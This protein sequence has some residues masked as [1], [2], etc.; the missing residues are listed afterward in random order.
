MFIVLFGAPGVGKG[1]QAEILSAKLNIA[2]FSTGDAFRAAI[3]NE[4]EVGLL[5]KQYVD[6]G[7]LVP[8]EVVTKIV[9]EALSEEKF[10]NGA[11]LDGYPRTTTQATS[12]DE[13]LHGKGQSIE[14]VVNI[15]VERDAI[16]ERLLARGR[17]DDTQEIIAN[18]LDVY[19]SETA[20]VL[21]YYKGK[22]DL[23]REVDGNKSI[24]EVTAAIL[25][26][27]HS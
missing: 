25:D 15:S 16:I 27:L 4:T 9:A 10:S 14:A 5:A 6:A 26:T 21:Q 22:Q 17:K 8:D 2:H 18:R 7:K 1:T 3:K 19:L 13:L 12:L 11:L 23:L 24:Q 20:P